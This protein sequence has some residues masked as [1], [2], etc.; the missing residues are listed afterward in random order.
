MVIS[1]MTLLVK[2]EQILSWMLDEF[3][4]WLKPYLLLSAT[5]DEILSWMIEF[6]LKHHSISNNNCNT[7]NL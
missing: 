4:H 6:W 2:S 3:I 1:R 7:A 5:S